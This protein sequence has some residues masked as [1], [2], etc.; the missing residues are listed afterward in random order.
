MDLPHNI[1][2]D[3]WKAG[4]PRPRFFDASGL[5]GPV[6]GIGYG[7]GGDPAPRPRHPNQK[8]LGAASRWHVQFEGELRVAGCRQVDGR[9]IEGGLVGGAGIANQ[10]TTV[11]FC[12]K[13]EADSAKSVTKSVFKMSVLF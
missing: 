9:R 10:R 2:S 1:R 12:A 11:L 7:A 3:V 6:A 4:P 13:V 8:H 5:V